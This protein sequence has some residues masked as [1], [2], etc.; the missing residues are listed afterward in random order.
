MPRRQT[1]PAGQRAGRRQDAA[2]AQVHHHEPA[3]LGRSHGAPNDDDAF[4]IGLAQVGSAGV[5]VGEGLQDLLHGIRHAQA[6]HG[7]ESQF[8]HLWRQAPAAVLPSGVA[9]F[10]QRLQEPQHGG[11]RQVDR[12]RQFS[13]RR[14]AVAAEGPH[15]G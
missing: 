9:L 1:Q 13:Q 4:R 6:F 10:F 5:S 7:R 2:D 14:P 3:P 8:E 15:D 12:A 11:V